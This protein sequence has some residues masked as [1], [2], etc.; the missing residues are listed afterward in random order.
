MPFTSKYKSEAVGS[1]A[2]G[3]LELK[4][5]T[6]IGIDDAMREFYLRDIDRADELG[7]VSVGCIYL[8]VYFSPTWHP[9]F[10][11]LQFT[12]ATSGMSR[13]FER[14]AS[15]RKMFTDLTASG[16]CCLLDAETGIFGIY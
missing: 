14:S 5:P 16:L 3:T 11:S 12:A 1:S 15:V 8:T 10:A 9:N 6:M 4:T 7:I 13:M 2:G